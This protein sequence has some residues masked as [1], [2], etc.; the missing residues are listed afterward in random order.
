MNA[1]KPLL[2]LI[3]IQTIDE[4]VIRQIRLAIRDECESRPTIIRPR[5]TRNCTRRTRID[6]SCVL[7]R[8][9]QIPSVQWKLLNR[10]LSNDILDG[11]TIRLE[12]WNGISGNRHGL[13][14]CTWIE[15]SIHARPV[16]CRDFNS[17]GRK[18]LE[19]RLL[20]PNRVCSR[21]Q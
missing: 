3:V 6:P 8:T 5:A 20:D 14:R 1:A 15:L 11:R 13:S 7:N 21:R 4:I 9:L 2:A 19:P 18:C 16:P 10:L 12:D 17:L